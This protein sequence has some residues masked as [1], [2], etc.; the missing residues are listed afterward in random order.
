MSHRGEGL[1]ICYVSLRIFDV[2]LGNVV[3]RLF[4]RFEQSKFTEAHQLSTAFDI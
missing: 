4:A 2:A 1:I 3:E